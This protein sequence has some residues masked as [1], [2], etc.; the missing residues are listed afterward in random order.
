MKI[1]SMNAPAFEVY[2]EVDPS[3]RDYA[4]AN[5]VIQIYRRDWLPFVQYSRY[6][7]NTLFLDSRQSMDK[8]RSSFKDKSF[9]SNTDFDP[10][11]I[12]E[13]FKNALIEE[14]T[15]NPPKAEIRATD[16]T[17]I[18]Q[19]KE[20]IKKLKNR[21]IV[22]RDISKYNRQINLP[23]HKMDYKNFKS[24][25]EDFDKM[26]LN[27]SDSEDVSFYEK[28]YQRLNYEIAGQYLINSCM[29][30]SRFDTDMLYNLSR[31]I[32]AVRAISMQC[33]VDKI[34]GEIKYR[35]IY[36]QTAYRVA[37]VSKDGHDD[38]CQGW[39]D[40]ITV[41]EWLQMVGDEFVWD[42][43]WKMLLWCLNW[44]NNTQFTGFVRTGINYSCLADGAVMQ[45]M[46]LTGIKNDNLINWDQAFTYKINVGYIEWNTWEATQTYL[47]REKTIDIKEVPYSYQLSKKEVKEGFEKESFYQQQWYKSYF[48][49]TSSTTQFIFDFGKVY[50]QTLHGSND[51]YASG[52]MVFYQQQGYSAVEISMPYIRLANFAFYRM[53][54][55]IMKA[56]PD[57]D[58]VLME[59]M[60]QITKGLQKLYPQQQGVNAEQGVQNLFKM[61]LQ[62]KEENNI[63]LRAL[64][65]VEGRTM[66][67]LPQIDRKRNGLDPVA[68]V[69]QLT[70]GW[71]EQQI[72][73]KIG[74]N[75]MRTGANP[76][77]RESTESETNT[78]QYS[79][80]STGYV[81]RM[82]QAMKERIATKTLVYSQ[83][84]IKFKESIPYKWL[85]R[86]L[87]NETTEAL[88]ML[89]EF[90]AHRYSLYIKDYNVDV[91]KKRVVDAADLA[92]QKGQLEYDQWFY[93]TQA[94]D[95]RVAV[96]LLTVFKRKKDKRDRQRALQDMQIQHDN[97]MAEL[98]QEK[99]NENIK[100]KWAFQ[101]A[102]KNAEASKY[103]ADKNAESR[104]EVKKITVD[105]EPEK[106]AAK[107]Q[108]ANQVNEQK[109]NLEDQKAFPVAS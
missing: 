25:V 107:A 38:I 97:K 82:L 78:I 16:P 83:L 44:S 7:T 102:S 84:I 109:K 61:Y 2:D 91:E 22:E 32:L 72:A 19:R 89:D 42:K 49:Q 28:E 108:G 60:I 8:V 45:G 43:H 11:G 80:N 36:P 92:L 69:M 57:S 73:S 48:L 14:L 66:Q 46:G 71:A 63:E 17:S 98:G 68:G 88:A 95:P 86:L 21:K 9:L 105:A 56:K 18:N 39:Q 53:L 47:S 93:I 104:I 51:E 87:G 30:L 103:S 62:F 100:G 26:G 15:K 94:E 70:V 101:V 6:T 1:I 106:Q 10:L 90:C 13:S 3:K 4:W 85:I 81:Y 33:Y 99:E 50:Y 52:S 29:S 79:I 76:P 75:P 27:D 65:Q 54:W 35:Y 96:K 34:T 77:S 59:E 37:G 55:A 74:I 12:M 67:Q 31:D 23:P 24:N 41:M 5:R 20:D 58:V 64:P 40:N